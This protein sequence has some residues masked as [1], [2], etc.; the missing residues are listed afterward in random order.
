MQMVQV[1]TSILQADEA[2]SVAE[3][4]VTFSMALYPSRELEAQYLTDQVC[5]PL[6][7]KETFDYAE[8][9]PDLVLSPKEA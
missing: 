9:D 4:V 2:L 6:V 1:N 7:A 8:R 3:N 5:A